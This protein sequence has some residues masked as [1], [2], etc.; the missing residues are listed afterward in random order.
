MSVKQWQIGSETDRPIIRGS[1]PSHLR[2]TSGSRTHPIR[3]SLT[4]LQLA[5][6]APHHQHR[7]RYEAIYRGQK[8]AIGVRDRFYGDYRNGFHTTL[9]FSLLEH[10][11]HPALG[12]RAG[13]VAALPDHGEDA[14]DHV[15]QGEDQ[16]A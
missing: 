1:V 2:R 11:Q 7:S 8:Q 12:E 10:P 16:E 9:P 15:E 6:E 4:T 13:R 5:T 3:A 14:A